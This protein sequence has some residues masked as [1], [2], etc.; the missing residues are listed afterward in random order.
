MDFAVLDL[1]DFEDAAG[2][3]IAFVGGDIGPLLIRRQGNK[4]TI[5]FLLAVSKCSH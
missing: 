2:A 4:D 1:G 3:V 5:H